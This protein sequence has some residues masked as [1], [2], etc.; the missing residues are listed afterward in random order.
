MKILNG[1]GDSEPELKFER[2]VSQNHWF[3]EECSRSLNAH[4][5]QQVKQGI[6]GECAN[7]QSHHEL[8]H[9]VVEDTIHQGNERRSNQ[10]QQTDDHTGQDG[11]APLWQRRVQ[12]TQKS[13]GQKVIL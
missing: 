9:V 11:V 13:E 1:H 5:G 6:S 3:T 8:K 4:M 7:G 2:S 10:A 12:K